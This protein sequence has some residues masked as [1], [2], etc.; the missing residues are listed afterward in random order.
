LPEGAR[1]RAVEH[2]RQRTESLVLNERTAGFGLGTE[3]IKNDQFPDIE[4]PR[5]P[6]LWQKGPRLDRGDE[7]LAEPNR[8]QLSSPLVDQ[9]PP[10]TQEGN[11]Q[12][13]PA[14]SPVRSGSR[15]GAGN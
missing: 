1:V 9:T 5:L 6:R 7:P 12:V 3:Q 4:A 2:E 10:P 14:V 11:P 8:L 15:G 13:L